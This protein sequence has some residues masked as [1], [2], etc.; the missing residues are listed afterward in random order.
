[1]NALLRAESIGRRF[2]ERLTLKAATLYAWPRRIT[3]LLGRNGCGKSTLLRIITGQLRPD[4]GVVHFGGR[5][6]LRPRLHQLARAG[7]FYIPEQGLLSRYLTLAHHLVL[8]CTDADRRARVTESAGLTELLDRFGKE[9][10]PGEQRRA[11]VALAMLRAP[12][13]LLADEPFQG[14]GPLDAERISTQLRSLK[15]RGC[16]IVVTGHEIGPLLELADEV[17]W[18]TAGTTCA[19][20]PVA[21]ARSHEQFQ[22][23]YLGKSW[24]PAR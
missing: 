11:D 7:L 9:L 14:I 12:T 16:A 21:V 2:G 8:T 20:G 22:R 19:L 23:E 5:V 10:S 13:C 17:V 18:L 1:M 15:E 6:Y 24:L 3:V 4:F